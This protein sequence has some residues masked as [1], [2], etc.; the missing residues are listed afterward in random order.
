MK[1]TKTWDKEKY[2][3]NPSIFVVDTELCKAVVKSEKELILSLL[4]ESD[5]LDFFGFSDVIQYLSQYVMEDLHKE[6]GT[7]AKEIDE[8]ILKYRYLI[9]TN[10]SGDIAVKKEALDAITNITNNILK[11]IQKYCRLLEEAVDELASKYTFSTKDTET[12][13]ICILW[14]I[15]SC[16]Q[17]NFNNSI[18]NIEVIM[19]SFPSIITKKYWNEKEVLQ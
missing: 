19:S 4:Q 11:R 7:H 3:D 1:T 18:E 10:K 9:D 8:L 5:W 15:P 14:S 13:I 17:K 16:F 2:V 12:M 6:I